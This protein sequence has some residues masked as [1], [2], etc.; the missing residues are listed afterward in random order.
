MEISYFDMQRF[1][2]ISPLF[3]NYSFLYFPILH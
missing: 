3:Y 2:T 1:A